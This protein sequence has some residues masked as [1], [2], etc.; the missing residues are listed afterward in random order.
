MNGKPLGSSA[1]LSFAN[2]AARTETPFVRI[3]AFVHAGGSAS[4]YA[5]W[6]RQLGGGFELVG[7]EL[8][9]HGSRV[10][11]E[12]LADVHEMARAVVKE[13]AAQRAGLPPMVFYGHSLGALV[14]YET[15][16]LLADDPARAPRHL[17]VSAARAPHLPR[18]T[19][20]IAHLPEDEFLVAVQQRYGGL[21]AA[22]LQEPELLELI[23]PALRADFAAFE[24][25]RYFV[26]TPLACPITAFVGTRDPL[27]KEAAVAEWSHHTT[28]PFLHHTVPGDHFFLA[29][30]R[31]QVLGILSSSVRGGVGLSTR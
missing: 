18:E 14:A 21:P 9:G 13:L 6:P 1:F 4:A 29:E 10:M 22:V 12:P 31:D 28:G 30:S 17:F 15:A 11:E 2:A 26:G 23:L 27:V 7:V 16:R 5:S 24:G 8:P 25:Y 3:L 20:D 19:T